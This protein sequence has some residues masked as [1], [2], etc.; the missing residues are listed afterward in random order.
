MSTIGDFRLFGNNQMRF[1][2]VP[3]EH[4]LNGD[5]SVPD[6]IVSFSETELKQTGNLMPWSMTISGY[7]TD[8]RSLP[9]IP[10]V[11]EWFKKVHGK[12]PYFGIL[13]SEFSVHSFV[14]SLIHIQVMG[15]GRS[16]DIT[17]DDESRIADILDFVDMLDPGHQDEYRP[18]F[19][20]DYVYS[21]N[22]QEVE[23]LINQIS[24]TGTM[25]LAAN[26]INSSSQSLIME[27]ALSRIYSVFS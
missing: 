18:Q 14:M 11:V 6:M 24:L 7:D 13:L 5:L 21:I 9:M 15:S 16:A 20:D 17:E 1:V 23:T 19:E 27:N 8:P 12:Y 25:F 3:K 26:E 2:P 10:E 22:P 4:I